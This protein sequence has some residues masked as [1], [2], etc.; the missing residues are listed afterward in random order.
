[1]MGNKTM[2]DFPQL[3]TYQ[4]RWAPIY[5]EPIMGS[6]ERLTAIIGAT[7]DDGAT[8]V[9]QSIRSDTLPCMYG[10]QARNVQGLLD[11][12]LKSFQNHLATYRQF[13]G[14]KPPLGGFYLGPIYEARSNTL[15]G[16]FR[17]AM[18]RMARVHASLLQ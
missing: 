12:V 11:L 1:M 16:V 18:V 15:Q 6:G 17:Q 3:P 4:A 5:W 14:W 8:N 7:G 13:S 2:T 9:I 10:A